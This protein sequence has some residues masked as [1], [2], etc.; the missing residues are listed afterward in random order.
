M[1]RKTARKTGSRPAR[2]PAKPVRK[3]SGKPAAKPARSKP[4]PKTK[5]ARRAGAAAGVPPI[6]DVSTGPGPTPAEIGARIC[7]AFNAGTGD[8]VA[9]S[10]WS[11]DIQSIEGMGKSFNGRASAIAKGEQWMAENEVLGAA[12]EGPYVG[13]T[14]FAL[15]FTMDVKN[16]ASGQTT[17][18]T[19]VGVYTVRNGKIVCEEFMYSC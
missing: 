5:A 7:A 3:A 9:R 10:F 17:R 15:K 2:K 11:E 14:G 1:A 12:A 6:T 8:E 13:A 19:E 16:K 4:A 18:M